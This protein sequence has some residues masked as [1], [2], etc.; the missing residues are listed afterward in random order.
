MRRIVGLETE[1]GC[2]FNQG[3]DL[4]SVPEQVKDYLI[5]EKKMGLID[6]HDRDYDEPA[7]NGGFLFNGGRLYIDMGHVEYCTSECKNLADLVASDY[8]GEKLLQTALDELGLS[9]KVSFIKNNIDH[10]TGATFGCHENY[11]IHRNAPLTQ[12][13]VDSLLAFLAIRGLMVGSGRVGSVLSS[14]KYNKKEGKT[15]NFQVMQRADYIQTEIYEWVQFNRALINARD[16]PLSD[17]C[18][19]RRLHLLLGDS[20]ILP[21]SQALKVGSTALVLDLLE[22]RKLPPIAF[23]DPVKTMRQVSHVASADLLIELA[24]GRKWTPVEVLSEYY[25]QAQK[26]EEKDEDAYW[27]LEAWEEVL[28]GLSGNQEKLIGKVDWITKKYLLESF[29]MKENIA[30]DDPWLDSL[31]LEYHQ[32]DRKKNFVWLLPNTR[33]EDLNLPSWP[34]TNFIADPPRNTRA[35]V[36]SLL[37]K[38]LAKEKV[39]YVIDWDYV[40]I[41]NSKFYSLDDPFIS[42][43]PKTSKRPCFDTINW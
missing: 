23:T 22:C 21:F 13:N 35:Y 6:V 25:L 18:R 41:G 14:R 24:D 4:L 1:Y 31:D 9:S 30:W 42:V 36:R 39:S 40:Q 28:E 10:Y 29:C 15:V 19:F 7:G 27:I 32:I 5:L 20:N 34:Q 37:M 12:E 38:Q 8:A 43:L 17:P 33:Y 2:L 26:L 3:T 11:L 16:E